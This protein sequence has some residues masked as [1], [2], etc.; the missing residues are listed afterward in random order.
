M[1]SCQNRSLFFLEI[2]DFL[3]S[4]LVVSIHVHLVHHP[5]CEPTSIELVSH[6]IPSKMSV[7]NTVSSLKLIVPFSEM[8]NR[9]KF[10]SSILL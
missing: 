7:K 4:Q 2:V 8:S 3:S 1:N 9:S 10:F 6:S 5:L